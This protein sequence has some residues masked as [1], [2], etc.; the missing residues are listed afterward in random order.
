M[1]TVVDVIRV[2]YRWTVA[3]SVAADFERWWH[4][5][6]I[7]IRSTYAGALG[8]L[9]LRSHSDPGDVVG[10]ARWQTEEHLLAFRRAAGSITFEGAELRSV[11]I[12]DE[13]DDL[14]IDDS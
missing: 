4:E 12:L 13:L 3:P 9:L 11:E 6:T 8:S 14:T 5:G 7:G 10:V 1:P 2:I